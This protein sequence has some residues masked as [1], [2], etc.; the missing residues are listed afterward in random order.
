MHFHSGKLVFNFK[1]NEKLMSKKLNNKKLRK[2]AIQSN[3]AWTFTFSWL[4]EQN[5]VLNTQEIHQEIRLDHRE[6]I[7]Y[8]L[9]QEINEKIN[10]V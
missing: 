6:N 7:L 9:D 10:F 8:P 4:N 1:L 2:L 5:C 3:S